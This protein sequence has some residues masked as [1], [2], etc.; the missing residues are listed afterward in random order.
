MQSNFTRN[1]LWL[2]RQLHLPDSTT[3]A[4]SSSPCFVGK[5]TKRRL[6]PKLEG[7][8]SRKCADWCLWLLE[9]TL[10]GRDFLLNEIL[11]LPQQRTPGV[12][13]FFL[14]SF[15]NRRVHRD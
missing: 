1:L 6:Y 3:M 5:F 8:H 15:S 9:L 2:G 4:D 14:L 12:V 7:R 13:C 11:N 10:V